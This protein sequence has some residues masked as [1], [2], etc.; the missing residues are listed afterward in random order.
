MGI[1]TEVIGASNNLKPPG[2][3]MNIKLMLSAIGRVWGGTQ[4]PESWGSWATGIQK[5]LGW[6]SWTWISFWFISFNKLIY[7]HMMQR[8]LLVWGIAIWTPPGQERWLCLTLHQS[9]PFCITLR[10]LLSISLS[11]REESYNFYLNSEFSHFLLCASRRMEPPLGSRLH[12]STY[13]VVQ[14]DSFSC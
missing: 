4:S 10:G 11:N 5:D 8:A 12:Y 9:L 1:E 3:T 6:A 13:Y 14:R 7:V 2:I